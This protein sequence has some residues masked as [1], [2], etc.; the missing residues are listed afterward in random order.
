MLKFLL[1]IFLIL[2]TSCHTHI[3]ENVSKDVESRMQKFMVYKKISGAV[4]LAYHKGNIIHH[5]AT[6]FAN[7]STKE[8][9]TTESLFRIASL[10]KN[11][12]AISVMTKTEETFC[13]ISGPVFHNVS[14]QKSRS[15]QSYL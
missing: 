1:T 5:Q 13:L 11:I 3:N 6:G 4:T 14:F 12:T 10:T 15:Q 7:I 9:M 2:I 8:K